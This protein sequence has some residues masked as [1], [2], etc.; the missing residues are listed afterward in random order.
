MDI[1]SEIRKKLD[2]SRENKKKP[3]TAAGKIIQEAFN[4]VDAPIKD[5]LDR[6]TAEFQKVNSEVQAEQAK[7]DAENKKTAEI[8]HSIQS[9]VNTTTI[10]ITNA[11]TDT[12]IV[13]I[14][15]AIGSEKSRTAY[16]GSFIDELKTSCDNLNPL[17]NQMKESIRKKADIERQQQAAELANDQ[18]KLVELMEAKELLDEKMNEEAVRIKEKAFEQAVSIE[19]PVIE[20]LSEVVA[21][22][23]KTWKWKV[24]DLQMLYKK[25]PH[26]VEL[27]PNKVK[28]QELIDTKKAEGSL[29]GIEELNIF[30]LTLYIEKLY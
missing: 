18:V 9:F 14:Q 8:K 2:E 28:I 1:I 26:L 22:R 12:E 20:S 13:R 25:M 23:R 10:A 16:Y 30:G 17:I 11:E 3:Y 19:T 21:P 6:K 29:K 5:I 15:K 4:E 24:D 7:I 27:T